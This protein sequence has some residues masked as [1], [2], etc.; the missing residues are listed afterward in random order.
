MHSAFQNPLTTEGLRLARLDRRFNEP[1][2]LSSS[3]IRS[4][5][6]FSKSRK[7]IVRRALGLLPATDCDSRLGHASRTRQLEK[8]ETSERTTKPWFGFLCERTKVAAC[9]VQVAQ[10]RPD[11]SRTEQFNARLSPKRRD[12]HSAV[13]GTPDA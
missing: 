12:E 2:C 9:G 5:F 11:R 8:R 3:S 13:F 6:V 7:S 1:A 10:T 4:V